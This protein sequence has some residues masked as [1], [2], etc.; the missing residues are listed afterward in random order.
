MSSF[1]DRA[2]HQISQLDKE[3][4]RSYSVILGLRKEVVKL[5]SSYFLN[6]TLPTDLFDL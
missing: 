1:Q 4:S 6:T 3:V 5:L 2:Q